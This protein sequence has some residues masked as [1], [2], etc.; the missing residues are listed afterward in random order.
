MS[1]MFYG[2]TSFN[3]SSIYDINVSSVTNMSHM[4]QGATAFN[5]ALSWT[6][7]ACLDASYMFYGATAY[8]QDLSSVD[9]SAVTDMSYMFAFASSYNQAVTFSAGSCLSMSH[10]FDTCLGFDSGV[11]L[12]S[13]SCLDMSYMFFSCS[14]LGTN[15]Y[16][17]VYVDTGACQNFSAMFEGC[18]AFNDPNVSS[19]NVGN[20]ISFNSMFKNASLFNQDLGYWAI[21]STLTDASDMLVATSFST[22]NYDILLNYWDYRATYYSVINVPLGVD[23]YYTIVNSGTAHDDLV[24]NQG[25]NISDLGGI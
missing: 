23:A 8:N 16:T 9:T 21:N 11:Y 18:S 25:W 4:F 22:T 19:F 13:S 6:S 1:Y 5:Q 20:A 14:L 10:M 2:A 7:A 15:P 24:N 3:H 12:Y 17:S